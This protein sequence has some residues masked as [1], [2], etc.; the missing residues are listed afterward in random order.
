MTYDSS[1]PF[2]PQKRSMPLRK[3]LLPLI[4]PLVL[5]VAGS[6]ALSL[7]VRSQ[8]DDFAKQLERETESSLHLTQH[9]FSDLLGLDSSLHEMLYT[10]DGTHARLSYANAARILSE[11]TFDQHESTNPI[12]SDMRENLLET[13]KLRQKYDAARSAVNRDWEILFSNLFELTSLMSGYTTELVTDY[14]NTDRV[15]IRHLESIAVHLDNLASLK[16]AI[17]RI[18][19]DKKKVT[20]IATL[21]IFNEKCS[22]IRPVPAQLK[23]SLLE[24][25]Q[26]RDQFL[27]S[28]QKVENDANSLRRKYS[29]IEKTGLFEQ[30]HQVT[31]FYGHLLPV[32]L[33][34]VIL[35]VMLALTAVIGAF[36]V[37]KPLTEL[38]TQ[39]RHFLA[40][41]EMPKLKARS[42]VEEINDVINWMQRFCKLILRNRR[43]LD[44]LTNRYGEL[45]IDAH[46]D[47][48]TGLANRKALEEFIAKHDKLPANATLLMIDLDFF[49]EINDVRGHIFGDEI[50]RVVA[51]HLRRNV[52]HSDPVYRYGGEEFCI[53]LTNVTEEEAERIA[54]RLVRGVRCISRGD[55]SVR[56]D[57]DADDPL[58]ISV[59]IAA[60]S[61]R[62]G[63][64]DF[65][66]LLREA[67]EALYEAKRSG[68][69]CARVF[70]IR[71]QTTL[72]DDAQVRD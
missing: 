7:S 49:K 30:I 43:D 40:T 35:A 63:E 53:F 17:A 44:S 3:F 11:T 15:T 69:N 54:W 61:E 14:K 31:L 52:S 71:T 70:R 33:A 58:T 68:R 25:E 20:D 2:L 36:F 27:A 18:C 66:S 26:I 56:A 59:G 28:A 60:V 13:W 72:K 8:V 48:L 23:V 32:F 34:F 57:R 4:L 10:S 12:I 47:P 22:E 41:Q 9:I 1:S 42:P 46:K 65:L 6:V 19:K 50:L 24:L 67:D 37:L 38:T 29:V 62:A 51:R 55:A 64:K 16:P 39:M 5:V 45:L 21:Q